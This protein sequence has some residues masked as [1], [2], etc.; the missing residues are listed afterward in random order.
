[1]ENC[2]KVHNTDKD[3][4]SD[5]DPLERINT[6]KK[7]S[8]IDMMANNQEKNINDI[9]LTEEQR[10]IDM[11]YL[12]KTLLKLTVKQSKN[13]EEG[14]EYIINSLGLLINNENKTK[15][16]LTIFGDV[17]VIK[18]YINILNIMI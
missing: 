3:L 2:Y 5:I 4:L 1:M 15:D 17:N 10:I 16:G 9:N 18:Y 8:N 7:L 11:F 12:S 14:K 6:Q 13:L